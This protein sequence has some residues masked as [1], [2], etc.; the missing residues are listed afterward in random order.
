MAAALVWSWGSGEDIQGKKM[1]S[2]PRSRVTPKPRG[3][4]KP[5]IPS[6]FCFLHSQGPGRCCIISKIAE[7]GNDQNSV[8]RPLPT[9]ICH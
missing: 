7:K 9:K 5:P 6:A 2:R 4:D 8:Q 1:V 3:V